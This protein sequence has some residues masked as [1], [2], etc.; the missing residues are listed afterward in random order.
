MKQ[1]TA[2]TA[3]INQGLHTFRGALQRLSLTLLLMLLTTASA[4]AGEVQVM[5]TVSY[6]QKV[7]TT[8]TFTTTLA[9]LDGSGTKDTWDFGT[10]WSPWK[11]DESHGVND[12]YDIKFK[13]NK[14]LAK[15][16]NGAIST[17]GETKFTVTVS[18]S[19]YYIKSVMIG[20]EAASAGLNAKSLDITVSSGRSINV[21][22][23]IL[24]DYYYGTITPQNGLTVGT[25]ATL[26]DNG[27]KYYKN[28]T[29]IT[30]NAPTNY[31]IDEASGVSG[32]SIAANKR[33]YT[34]TM[35]KQN[36]T[37]GATTSEVHTI[38]SPSGL[39]VTTN[40]YFT[41][42]TTKYYKKDQTYTLTVDDANKVIQSFTASGAS[43]SSVASDKR[44]ATVT[45]GTSNVTVSATLLT[46]TGSCG[47]G[48]TWTMS[49]TD[50]NGTYDRLTLSGSGMLST[51]PWN[52]DF[53]SSI[54]RVDVSSADITI[55]G[56]PFSKL[57]SSVVI[58]VPTPAYA[59]SYAN[60]GFASKL[61]VQFGNYLFSATNEGGSPAYAIATAYDL[62]HLASA[63][64]NGSEGI[65]NG[66]TFRQTGNITCRPS[67]FMPIGNAPKYFSG[68]Y[69]GGGY[70]ISG[71]SLNSLSDVMAYGLFGYVKNGLVENVR[72]VSP[73]VNV[74]DANNI[75]YYGAL[76][77][78]AGGTNGAS[79]TIRNCVVITPYIDASNFYHGLIIG[80]QIDCT[81][82]NL[83]VYND[84]K[85][86]GKT[87]KVI[88][89][90]SSGTNVGRA[91]KVT[92]GAGIS[93]VS[94]A[95]N[96]A[97]TSLDNGFSYNDYL[98]YREGVEL[99]LASDLSATGKH[100]VYKADGTLPGNTYTVS[101][102]DVSLTAELVCN[103]YTITYDLDGGSVTTANPTT[104]NVE[105]A[106]F[107]LNN[108]TKPGYTFIG[109]TE[110]NDNTLM[111]T[112]TIT[113]GSSAK[114]LDYTAHYE[115]AR[116]TQG[117]LSYEW[118]GSGTEVEVTACD[119]SVTSVTIPA[120]VSNDNVTYNVTAIDATAFSGCNDLLCLIL[121]SETPLTLGDNAFS[122]CTALN[123][124]GVP[125]GAAEAYKTNWS[126][127]AEK[128]YAID[129]TCGGNVYYTYD[130]TTKTLN[131]FGTG[132]MKGYSNS[133]DTP[134]YSYREDIKTI[135]IGN[136][137]TSIGESAFGGCIVLTSIIIPAS[138][139]TISGWAFQF[140]T[141]LNSI[142]IPD[143]VTSIGEAAFYYCS[144]LESIEIPA[145]VTTIG[146]NA[147]T[148]CTSLT[149][150]EIPASVTSIGQ[151]AFWGCTNL[152]VVILE[153]AT[154]PTLGSYAFSSC[155]A[156]NAIGV[157]AGT[158][159]AYKT[160]WSDYA[161]KIYAI[162]GKCGTNVY[163]TYDN[164]SKTLNI[165]G[166]GAMA[167]YSNSSNRPWH[168]D[169][170]A[171]TT[172]I[173]SDG[174]TSI[175][176]RAFEGCNSL[177]SIEIP[178]SVMTI[179]EAAFYYCSSLESIEIPA[180]V[181]TIGEAAFLF[182]T[183]LASVT[184][185]APELSVYG[186]NAF[187]EN[188]N[189]RKIYVPKNSV[190]TYKSGWSDYASDIVGF[191]ACGANVYYTYDNDTKTLNIF[192]TGYMTEYFGE[193]IPWDEYRTDITT[194]V[195]GHG[196]TSIGYYAFEFC[197]NLESIEIPA[198]VMMIGHD[199]F[200]GCTSLKNITI[201]A[202][203]TYIDNYAFKNCTGL[204]SIEI[205]ASVTTIGENAFCYCSSLESIEI[206]ANVTQIGLNPFS[207]CSSLKTISVASG[208]TVF[209]SRNNCNAIIK[210][211]MNR[212]IT[213]C[214]N[215]VIPN[216]VTCIDDDAFYG[217][218]GL[219]SIEIPASV[220]AIYGSA[221]EGCTG[222]T[223]IEIPASVTN[224]G[225]WAFDDCTSLNSVTIYA[226]ELSEYGYGYGAF[227]NN[228][229]GRKIYV[230]KNSVDTY[231]S[232][233][234]NYASD[235]V[236]FDSY[237]DNVYYTYDSSTKTLYF[238]GTG[239]MTEYF[240][241][242]IPW[243]N[244]RTDIT[245]VVIGHG[246]T[247]IG[248]MAFSDC[249]G[250]TSI[251]IPA[252]VM[253]IGHDAFYGCTSLKSITIPASVAYI[254]NCAFKNCTG[255]TSIDI[256]ASVTSIGKSVFEN[257][258]GLTSI[259]I[260]ANVTQIDSNPFSGCSSLKT[261]SVA[262]GNTVFD[263]RNN[264][265]AII[266]KEMNRLITGCKNSVIPNG[267]TCIDDDAFY[268][269]TGLTSIEIPA[270]VTAIYGSAFEGC[271]GLTSIEIPASVTNI[272]SWA[273][274]D[275][276]SLNSVTI[277]APELSEYGYGYGAFD[278][279]ADGRKIYVFENCLD[280]YKSGWSNY[281]SDIE[282]IT[283]IS[284]KDNDD[285]RS[286]VEAANGNS[287]NVTLQGRKLY[288][289]GAWNTLCLPF[290]VT[291]KESVLDGDDVKAMVL[292]D[293][294]SGLNGDQL[295]LNFVDAPATIPAGTPFIIKWKKAANLEN[296]VFNGVTINNADHEVAFNG[297]WFMG[298]YVP[299][300]WTEE[301]QNY[302]FLGDAN[303]LYYPKAGAHLNAFRAYF[304]LEEPNG[305]AREIVVNFGEETT[306]VV[307]MYN[308]QCTMNNKAD[309]WYTVNG[310]KLD[311][312][313]TAKG[314][315]I[316]N[317]K[318]VV[319][320]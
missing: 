3:P 204:T 274:D 239:D 255:L 285:N 63:I 132:A 304:L 82:Q 224:I 269:C 214:K 83:Y 22:T 268:G 265:N 231:K 320:K 191:D 4:W 248:S 308:E 42:N 31:I 11:A 290:D 57:G 245:T 78:F 232:G 181:T 216:G 253:I 87:N 225:S 121:N 282:A 218:T 170:T 152:L 189:G 13:P 163:Y 127:Y 123:A 279:N 104:Y 196:V 32:T 295:T 17:S 319:I 235:I 164:S 15:S 45:I 20:G 261:I 209:D 93:S 217:C 266:K 35:P 79:T 155:T 302:L 61:R 212:L 193:H 25:D 151:S 233:W 288:K 197:T 44:S 173:I 250:L 6:A 283:A 46:I 315:Y 260:P 200:N 226:P 52:T 111:P 27:T 159:E 246:V 176:N 136:G 183:N 267:V 110:G 117:S 227:D 316:K 167:D 165:F 162:D 244:Y 12:E 153:S 100:V 174:V 105:T 76:I 210:K 230:P 26:T 179:G 141:S 149:S 168:S 64:N 51:S 202:S 96:P 211:E 21:L 219:T 103:T 29:T 119:P 18:A 298:T 207:G 91:R 312:K 34:F 213:G 161:E 258:T 273:F 287:L 9:R 98:Y 289:D 192:G 33:S 221:F 94:P 102:S 81:L 118:T 310:V 305:T 71:L 247:S 158:A 68:N 300:R 56:N 84:E 254:D 67:S 129:G 62:Q 160:N 66:K 50:S 271:T 55:S 39:T 19:A 180:S 72:L 49:D 154:P 264:C 238:F 241:G 124:I 77:G 116:F 228:A 150:I 185:Y 143:G 299:W 172:V 303:T 144:S 229:D 70:T 69:D 128:I 54:S 169:C 10:G 293:K 278:N 75:Y 1:T 47:T 30:M 40:P 92:L 195:I 198:S 284:L 5:Y 85:F 106:T 286:L 157:P 146:A 134:W 309:A 24:T 178:S 99:T 41:Y 122:A 138:V 262:S 252:S 65:A 314:M 74:S 131:I 194:V 107:T 125:A 133:T 276:T 311:G 2:N 109:W 292:D 28:G 135:V 8:S 313:P 37:P 256:P 88:G 306:G 130:S 137:V 275:C 171:I 140:C 190:D 108:P 48:L 95:I 188:A 89:V 201:P 182:C 297:G 222:L 272:G 186:R 145:S 86:Q 38:S 14:D 270:S 126:D 23:V 296:P 257:C 317:G 114:D 318:K 101:S 277:Y 139:T 177:T 142:E 187:S 184:I 294:T 243:Y 291:I 53:A 16:N 234:S 60:A 307:S 36:V 112:V 115:I 249:T 237:G 236:G 73:K 263:S 156:L 175:G 242:H 43:G 97:A 203:V 80:Q 215:S 240:G 259:E 90:G 147:F 301:N 223:S 148:D 199:A 281:A 208:N 220:T 59:V 113:K 120:T 251:E 206:P 58:V 7:G 280:T 205:P 166:T